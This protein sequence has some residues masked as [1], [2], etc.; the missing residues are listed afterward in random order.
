[1]ESAG[2]SPQEKLDQMLHDGKITEEDYER[3][4]KVLAE[5]PDLRDEKDS[6][7]TGQRRLCKSWK[8]RKVGGV[9]AGIADYFEI[10]PM[11]VRIIT[12]VFAF[13]AVPAVLVAYFVMYFMLPWDDEEA[14][15]ELERLG[16]LVWCV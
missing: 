10:D 3:L 7:A 11:I 12:I 16:H 6:K 1:M 9:C 5:K 15:K 14:D 8:Q 13:M 2:I 4:S